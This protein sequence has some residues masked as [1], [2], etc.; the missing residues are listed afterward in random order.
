MMPELESWSFFACH[1]CRYEFAVPGSVDVYIC[2]YCKAE[3]R[4]DA[5]RKPKSDAAKRA[6]LK[7]R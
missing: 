1:P 3:L 2:S 5:I 4:H 7:K 6:K